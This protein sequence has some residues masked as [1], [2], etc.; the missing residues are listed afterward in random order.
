MTTPMPPAVRRVEP[1]DGFVLRLTFDSGE[2]GDLDVAPYLDFG[3]FCRLKEPGAFQ[4][5]RVAFN[6]VEWECLVDLDPEFV[7]EKCRMLAE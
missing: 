5:V 6:T 1:R 3:V 7:Y 4:A 2:V